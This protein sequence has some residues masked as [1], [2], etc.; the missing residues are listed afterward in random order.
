VPA[1]SGVDLSDDFKQSKKENTFGGSVYRIMK[2]NQDAV[3]KSSGGMGKRNFAQ[4]SAAP[5]ATSYISA[6]DH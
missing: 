1:L 4:S 5:A 2:L 3:S 6:M